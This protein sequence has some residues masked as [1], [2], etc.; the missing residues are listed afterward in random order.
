MPREIRDLERIARWK[1][2]K[3]LNL[4]NLFNVDRIKALH[5]AILV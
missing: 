1:A 3:K 4:F 5:F 2:T